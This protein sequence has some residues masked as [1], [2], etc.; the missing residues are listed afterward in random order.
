[1]SVK[2]WIWSESYEIDEHPNSM[3][4]IELGED[5]TVWSATQIWIYFEKTVF[6]K[7]I[8]HSAQ[9]SH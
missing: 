9:F 5:E 3:N 4:M 7:F 2:I 8:L 1:M 6:S